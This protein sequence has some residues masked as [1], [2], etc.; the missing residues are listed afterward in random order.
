MGN[1]L[2]ELSGAGVSIWLDDLSRARLNSGSLDA[3][4][5]ENSVVG[6][7]TNPTIFAK[8]LAH[9][10]D[11][12][13]QLSD[14]GDIPTAT[15][16]TQ[17]CAADVREACDRFADIY[18]L[19][20]GFDGRVSIEVSPT[21]AHDAP[22]TVEEAVALRDLVDRDNV[23]IKIPATQEG[24]VAIEE[25]IARGI[26][27]NV[28]LIFSVARYVQVMEAYVRGLE[29]ADRAGLDLSQI[30]S[31]ASFFIS[32]VDSE[33]DRRL[34]ALGREEL[35]GRAAVSNALVAYGAFEDFRDSERFAALAARGANI[36]R[37]LW[38]STGTKDPA[39]PDTVYVS[40]LV[41]PGVVNTMPEKTLL[42]FAD[43]GRVGR[44]V[45][46]RRPEGEQTLGDIARAGVDLDEVFTLLEAQG[47]EKFIASW[48]ELT[49]SVDAA[50]AAVR[51]GN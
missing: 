22:S 14:L 41:G 27:V 13:H 35:T 15:A 19:S 47:I 25:V 4:I 29:R 20:K 45:E 31:V 50:M 16:I 2:R 12:T 40:D 18:R 46:G 11:Y 1:R 23:L 39:L 49:D 43:H 21:L 17:L 30:H 8:A 24:L 42:A 44:S 3:L 34:R 28:T 37:P 36:Q 38:A 5:R 51:T 7:T 6:V 26:S 9:G 10:E 33:V 32:R 48:R